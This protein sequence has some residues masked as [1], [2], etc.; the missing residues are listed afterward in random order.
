M[1]E[2]IIDLLHPSHAIKESSHI[3]PER[4]FSA[5]S[6]EAEDDDA[7][8]YEWYADEYEAKEHGTHWFLG[9]GAFALFLI[10]FGIFAHSYFFI[11]FVALAFGVIVMYA[12]RAPR[13]ILFMIGPA[14]VQAGKTAYP[15]SE[16]VSFSVMASDGAQE[17][18][19]ETKKKLQPFVRFPIGDADTDAIKHALLNHIPEQEHKDSFSD[20]LARKIGL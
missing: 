8:W 6:R 20:Q 3:S 14:G 17:L 5:Y 10:I 13:E 2:K 1:T 7:R 9:M 16:L 11:A 12:K 15:F 4:P 19:L 18:S